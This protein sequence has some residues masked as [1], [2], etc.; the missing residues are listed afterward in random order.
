MRSM[1]DIDPTDAN[2]EHNDRSTWDFASASFDPAK[3]GVG[4]TPFNDPTSSRVAVPSTPT[5]FGPRYL[6]RLAGVA[7]APYTK[8]R[9]RG[10]RQAVNIGVDIPGAT[11]EPDFPL[12]IDQVSPFWSFIDGNISWHLRYIAGAVLA[13]NTRNQQ[14]GQAGTSFDYARGSDS[15]VVQEGQNVYPGSLTAPAAAGVPPGRNI[16]PLGTFRDLRYPWILRTDVLD[17]EV[18][19]PGLL[20]FFASVK[21]TSPLTRGRPL[22]APN[23]NLSVLT[24]E[25]QFV[26]AYPNARYTYVAGSILCD[27]GATTRRP[28]ASPTQGDPPLT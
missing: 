4:S 16:G 5:F 14:S 26:I 17:A 12:D 20:V 3:Q 8:C 2:A 27:M 11:N 15:S 1:R 10:I 19:G 22:L 13:G 25:D 18:I 28:G 23:A 24:R 21:Q 9:I 6:I 7:V